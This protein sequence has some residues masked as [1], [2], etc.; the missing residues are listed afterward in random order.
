MEHFRAN[1][2]NYRLALVVPALFEK[3]LFSGRLTLRRGAV[4]RAFDFKEGHLVA[5]SSSE[6][7]EHLSQVLCNLNILDVPRSAAA[8]EAAH[9]AQVSLGAYLIDRG[10]VDRARLA[11]ALAHKAREGFFDCYG[12]ESGEVELTHDELP[13][14]VG[15]EL[16]LPLGALHRDGM[17]RLREW[18]H[19]RELFPRTDCTFRVHREI[20][21]DW[22]SDA[23][24]HLLDLAEEGAA[25]GELL[26][27]DPEGRSFAARRVLQLY[28]RGVLSPRTPR[29]PKVGE[30]AD[31]TRLIEL[32][33]S[34]LSDHQFEAAAAVAA[35][36]MEMAP[37]AEACAL[38]REAEVRMGLQ[39]WDE[40]MEWE[41]RLEFMPL[42]KPA[43][44][45]LTAD[46]LY[47]HS[48]LKATPSLRQ[49]LRGAAMGELAAYRS[50]RKLVAAGLVRVRSEG[51]RRHDTLP[52][53]IPAIRA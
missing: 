25:L 17:A 39:I 32:T 44:A 13:W 26:A 51:S 18:R 28:R 20:A 3:R 30:S 50:I 1:L 27:A 24:E 29:G 45:Q 6:A 53:G 36:A 23:E 16:R 12:W 34:L 22:R 2:A 10:F 9:A 33:R 48:L 11:E 35:Q 42:P 19:F 31:I 52:Y 8:F 14:P 47:V 41:D 46:D 21:V 40:V 49:A 37:V 15:V 43:P 7:R 38:Y 5:A 4:E